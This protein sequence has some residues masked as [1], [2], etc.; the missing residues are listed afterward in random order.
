[1]R[2]TL[3]LLIAAV[4]A[5][6]ACTATTKAVETAPPTGNATGAT[7]T[8]AATPS[9]PQSTAT[10]TSAPTD[11][12][13]AAG[14]KAGIVRTYFKS[15]ADS[16]GYVH[17]LIVIEVK[18]T[19][20]KV[21]NIHSG[22]QSYTIQGKDGS[23][24]ETSTFNYSFPQAVSPGDF[25]YYIGGGEY[26]Q[27]TKAA[28]VGDLTPSLSYQDADSAPAAWEFSNLKFAKDS[29]FEGIEASGMVKNSGDKDATMGTVGCV[30][31]AAN[32]DILGGVVDNSSVMGLRAGQSKGFK[33]SY[34]GT[35]KLDPATI[36]TSKCFGQDYLFF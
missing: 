32:G 36:K 17:Y 26:S 35:P 6:S 13:A 23:V 3:T 18:N 31:F 27:G 14:S 16:I 8:K 22:D 9:G 11:A 34:P 12:P 15:W 20:G 10:P 4:L 1:M 28:D 5:L 21:A 24:L 2:R 19:G 25:G 7:A 33:T 30:L 29:L